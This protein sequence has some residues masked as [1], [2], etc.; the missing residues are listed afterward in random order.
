MSALLALECAERFHKADS[1]AFRVDSRCVS[2]ATEIRERTTFVCCSASLLE[3]S[4]RQ[5]RLRRTLAV[6]FNIAIMT[7]Q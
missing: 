3:L 2:I 6:T 5:D 4:A 1:I 7:D